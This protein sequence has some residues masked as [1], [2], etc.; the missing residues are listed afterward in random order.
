M[1][2]GFVNFYGASNSISLSHRLIHCTSDP[3]A[4]MPY[5]P[6]AARGPWIVTL[7]GAVVHD[8]GGYGT[9]LP[10]FRF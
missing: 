2:K 8:N 3:G 6:L 5:I 7:H 10:E 1:Q 9:T 4:L